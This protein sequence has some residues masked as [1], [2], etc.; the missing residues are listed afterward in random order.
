MLCDPSVTPAYV[1][2]N[3]DLTG[4]TGIDSNGEWYIDVTPA[5][6]PNSKITVNY[7]SSPPVSKPYGITNHTLGGRFNTKT[8][9]V[10]GCGALNTGTPAY[11]WGTVMYVDTAATPTFFIMTTAADRQQQRNPNGLR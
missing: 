11:I 6:S 4:Q 9:V 5:N 7:S 2:D 8:G 10:N 1:G 3:V